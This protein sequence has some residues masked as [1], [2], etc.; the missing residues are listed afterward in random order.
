MITF[1]KLAVLELSLTAKAKQ[2]ICHAG[3]HLKSY[4]SNIIP[5]KVIFGR[6][7]VS[8]GNVVQW[9]ALCTPVLIQTIWQLG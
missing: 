5:H 9:A 2:L 7:D 8:F 3:V 1:R 6:L 4:D